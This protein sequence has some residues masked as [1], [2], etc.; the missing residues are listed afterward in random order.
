M[1]LG[2]GGICFFNQTN[3]KVQDAFLGSLR[4]SHIIHAFEYIL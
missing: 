4:D 1:L 3:E 2:T